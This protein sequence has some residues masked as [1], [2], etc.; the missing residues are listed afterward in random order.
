MN[1][2]PANDQSQHATDYDLI[3]VGGGLVGASLAYALNQQPL[4]IAII[5]A[6]S[7]KTESQPNYDDRAIALS[8]GTRRVFEG[9]GLWTNLCHQVTSIKTIHV[10]DR[11]HFGVTRIK[12]TEE[13]VDALGYVIAARDLGHTLVNAINNCHNIDIISPAR[14][15]AVSIEDSHVSIETN[16]HTNVHTDAQTSTDTKTLTSKLIVAADGGD[17]SVRAMM[18]I[19]AIETDYNQTAIIAN[20]SSSKPHQ[21]IAYERF[22]D[23]GPMAL[24]PMSPLDE[25][26]NRCALV[27][28][29][30]NDTADEIMALDDDAF[31][32]MLQQRFGNR[33]GRFTK[34]GKRAS[35]TLRMIQSTE[36][37]Q[38]RLAIIG[39]AAHTLHPIAGQGFNLGVR[40]VA[41][42]AQNIVD[43]IE[44][45]QDI[46]SLSVLREY[47]QW[48]KRDQQ[49]VSGFTDFLVRIFSNSFPPLA[50]ARNVGLVATDILPSVK[51]ALAKRTMGIA[52]K[53]PRLARGLPL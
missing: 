52:G 40:D 8:Y 13:N 21:H 44:N 50:L 17:S 12:H 37:I 43:A 22:T 1:E 49:N 26:E 18:G 36:Q 45:K 35:H 6:A 51:H 41:T 20:V 33:M 38:S 19:E 29:Q 30:P 5:E 47:A 34:I 2:Q 23:D 14:V 46:G 42:L 10:S 4:R 9:M 16:I 31:L 11:G 24:L 28:T 53:L 48:R 25:M 27:W 15:K 3:I 39:N 32:E 7:F